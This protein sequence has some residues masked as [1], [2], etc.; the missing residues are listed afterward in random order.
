MTPKQSAELERLNAA[1]A[2]TPESVSLLYK[3]ARFFGEQTGYFAHALADCRR[4]LQI[5]WDI[6]RHNRHDLH[7][8][9]APLNFSRLSWKSFQNNPNEPAAQFGKAQAIVALEWA[10]DHSPDLKIWRE[11]HCATTVE[12]L[13]CAAQLDIFELAARNAKCD[14]L[15]FWSL[16]LVFA[17]ND[18][19][20]MTVYA[21]A[22]RAEIAA[23]VWS[24]D[25]A[26]CERR[27]RSSRFAR[28]QQ[29]AWL[30]LATE[31]APDDPRWLLQRAWRLRGENY[32]AAIDDLT[33]AIALAPDDPRGYEMRA[34][35][36]LS[37]GDVWWN[38]APDSPMPAADH[39]RALR[40]RTAR[41]Q[42]ADDA[43]EL[44]EQG[45]QLIPRFPQENERAR[46]R[47]HAFYSLAIEREPDNANYYLARARTIDTLSEAQVEIGESVAQ[48]DARGAH[49][50]YR[51]ALALNPSL[52]IARA[53]IIEH[54]TQELKRD[55]A[56]EQIEALLNARQLLSSAGIDV[57]TARAI[58]AEVERALAN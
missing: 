50:D 45:D 35:V 47:A 9:D 2:G 19:V 36:T 6:K 24:D 58:I 30:H 41:G 7:P 34:K 39:L 29:A 27:S 13:E 38:N 5:I 25:A 57:A 40:L 31:S 8:V 11:R 17:Q 46:A 48:K 20:A 37:V 16:A 49:P 44:A 56:H 52:T 12:I 53:K 23:G 51:R 32:R 15:K 54:W 21:L 43:A 3:R 22:L 1:I 10:L 55:T 33:R 18:R 28:Y 26:T 42:I 14:E 4:A